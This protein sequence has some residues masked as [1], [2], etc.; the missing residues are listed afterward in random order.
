MPLLFIS[1]SSKDK[2]KVLTLAGEL[3]EAG[4]SVWLD[5]WQI[6]VGESI[7]IRIS[8]GIE[9]ARFLLLVLSRSAVSSG[10]VERE[11]TA[12]YWREATDR[13]VI[14]LPFLVEQCEIPLL[15]RAKKHVDASADWDHAT[16]ELIT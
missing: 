10:W 15:L 16:F 3:T 1:H 9:Q 8:D 2:E 5:E 4:L 7:P 14:V 11:W 12:A 6:R 13:N